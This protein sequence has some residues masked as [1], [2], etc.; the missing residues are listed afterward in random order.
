MPAS[1]GSFGSA[2]PNARPTIF[3]YWP[4]APKLRPSKAGDSTRSTTTRVILE[5]PVRGASVDLSPDGAGVLVAVHAMSET[6]RKTIARRI[7]TSPASQKTRQP[8]K[9]QAGRG[10][11]VS[12]RGTT[13]DFRSVAARSRAHIDRVENARVDKSLDPHTG[14]CHRPACRGLGG[15][16]NAI[17]EEWMQTTMQDL[18]VILENR[19]GTLAKAT[20]AIA[21]AGNKLQGGPG[22]HLGGEE[23][24]HPP[25]R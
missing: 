14:R 8:V 22:I 15:P 7:D 25:L 9:V 23:S 17:R 24:F 19:P 11:R 21:S 12:R 2:T 18:T 3:S 1:I 6:A 16:H 13:G 10:S 4:T 5:S 20:S